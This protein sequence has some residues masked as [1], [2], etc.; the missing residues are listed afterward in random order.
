MFRKFVGVCFLVT[1]S[2]N[3]VD[4]VVTEYGIAPLRGRSVMD[5]VNNLIAIAHPNF[6]V[7]LKRQAE[8]LKIW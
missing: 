4:Y 3:D 2:K 5:R 8:E 6:R 1:L 7:E